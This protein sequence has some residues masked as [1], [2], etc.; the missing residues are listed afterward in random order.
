MTEL[1][2]CAKCG[3]PISDTAIAC[4][5]C[6]FTDQTKPAAAKGAGAAAVGAAAILLALGPTA[7]AVG[8]LAGGSISR[9][10]KRAA[11]KLQ[12]YDWF[13]LSDRA[14]AVVAQTGYWIF[15]DPNTSSRIPSAPVEHNDIITC[16]L[17]ET[18]SREGSLMRMEKT[19]LALRYRRVDKKGIMRDV[20]EDYTFSGKDTRVRASFAAAKFQEYS[21][22]LKQ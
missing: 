4:P 20:S 5:F 2:P 9:T 11:K 22:H 12:G 15:P 1:I 13:W 8:L 14:V 16:S 3:S 19:V 18:K 17:D 7:L 6:G 21:P 10:I